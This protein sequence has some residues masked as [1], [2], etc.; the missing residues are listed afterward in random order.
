MTLYSTDV[1][2]EAFAYKT[3]NES[4]FPEIFKTIDTLKG[5]MLS[6]AEGEA[7]SLSWDMHVIEKMP[8]LKTLIEKHVGRQYTPADPLVVVGMVNNRLITATRQVTV[9][10]SLDQLD[11]LKGYLVTVET[12]P[13][14]KITLVEGLDTKVFETET[15]RLLQLL[16][17]N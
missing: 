16:S 5:R 12:S 1:I 14:S 9:Q 6:L 17:V 8:N 15:I 3:V 4:N 13:A 11:P 2:R 7:A 10:V